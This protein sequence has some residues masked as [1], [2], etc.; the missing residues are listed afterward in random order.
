TAMMTFTAFEANKDKD[1]DGQERRNL[2]AAI[3]RETSISF[4]RMRVCQL[5]V[6]SKEVEIQWIQEDFIQVFITLF[7]NY[8][9]RTQILNEATQ[10]EIIELGRVFI[11]ICP[12][13]TMAYK[14]LCH[15]MD[16]ISKFPLPEE[17]VAFETL[18]NVSIT[19][20]RFARYILYVRLYRRLLQE[21]D[22]IGENTD[23]ETKTLIYVAIKIF[24]E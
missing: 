10:R 21:Y 7:S 12:S 24:V 9:R 19:T 22:N 16:T 5:D 1:N 8:H 18:I 11:W 4:E 6:A 14:A 2:C 13:I 15:L 3:C 23:D 20:S 17:L